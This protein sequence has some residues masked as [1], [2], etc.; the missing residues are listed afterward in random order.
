MLNKLNLAAGAL[1]MAS[2][3]MMINSASAATINVTQA[4]VSAGLEYSFG[5]GPYVS[6]DS[7]SAMGTLRQ[8][9]IVQLGAYTAGYYPYNSPNSIRIDS[10]ASG[11]MAFANQ[12][13]TAPA[14]FGTSSASIEFTDIQGIGSGY[15]NALASEN[16]V[17]YEFEVLDGAVDYFV[18]FNSDTTGFLKLNTEAGDSVVDVSAGQE[19]QGSLDPG[20]YTLSTFLTVSASSLEGQKSGSNSFAMYFEDSTLNINPVPIPAAAWLF[21]SALLG[22]VA[23]KRKSAQVGVAMG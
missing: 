18:N 7:A 13:G 4:E 10:T 20:I 14:I 22:L 5:Y 6:E 16:Y 9:A 21:G 17:F 1:G 11:S 15:A 2:I 3:W 8:P 23:V 12:P 19:H